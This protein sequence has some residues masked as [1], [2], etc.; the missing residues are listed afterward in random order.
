[1]P[2]CLFTVIQWTV[3]WSMHC[4][5]K[6]QSAKCFSAKWHRAN[7]RMPQCL[8]TFIQW[9]V[10]WSMHCVDQM[11]VGQM[12]FGETTWSLFLNSKVLFSTQSFDE[13]SFGRWVVSTK[14]QFF[15]IKQHVA[16]FGIPNDY[17]QHSHLMNSPLVNGLCQP[18]VNLP[19]VF[20]PNDREPFF[21][22]HN[23]FSQLFD[24]Q[25]LGQCVVSIK[26]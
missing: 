18:N 16:N 24:E 11:S 20:L 6:C 1:M 15:L 10:T 26:C 19:N 4:V 17:F 12:F 14:C 22:C 5:D 7:F 25:S 23:V 9:T 13:W 3:A 21:E 2:Q 8:F